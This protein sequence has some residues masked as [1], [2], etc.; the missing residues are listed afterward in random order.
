M[1]EDAEAPVDGAE[2]EGVAHADPPRS[3]G[4]PGREPGDLFHLALVSA[5]IESFD[6]DYRAAIDTVHRLADAL[7]AYSGV[8]HV[9]VLSLPL[10]L[11]SEQALVGDAGATGASADFEI[12]MALRVMVPGVTEA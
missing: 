8:E 4:K 11:S 5:R 1:S 2:A 6:G 12:R 9:R 7:A 3:S 10:N